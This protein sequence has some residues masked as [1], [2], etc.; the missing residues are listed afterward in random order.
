M[1]QSHTLD[2]G[3]DVPQASIA[4]ADGATDPGAAGIALGTCG[5]RPCARDTRMRQRPSQATPRVLV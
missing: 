3:M 2:V 4:V 5:P 1:P